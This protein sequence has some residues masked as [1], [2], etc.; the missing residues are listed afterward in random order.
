LGSPNWGLQEDGSRVSFDALR[1]EHPITSGPYRIE[2]AIE[3]RGITYHR[4]PD[5]WGTN[6]PSRRGTLNFDQVVYKLYKDRDTQ[7]SALRAGQ[8][9]FFMEHQM[10]YWCCQYIGHRFNS[11]EL[12]KE[13]VAHQNP[14]AM[15][16]HGFNLRHA[17]FQDPK[18]REALNYALDFEWV[19]QKI[20]DNHFGRVYSYFATT[21]LAASGL[22]SAEELEILEPWR[23]QLDPAV[24]GPMVQLPTTKAPS[25]LRKNLM[26]SLELFAE[27]GW[28]YR[29]GA[30]RNKAGEPFVIEVSGSRG[31]NML[32]DPY[33]LNLSKIGIEVRRRNSDAAT[34][35]ALMTDFNFDF[36]P[37]GLREGRMPG[38]ELWRKFNSADATVPGSE[39]IL[40][41]SSPVIDALINK[42]LDADSEAELT[43]TAR[44]LDRVL[45]HGHYIQ[46]WRY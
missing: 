16:G 9:D 19:N 18:V 23:E 10:R 42:L 17:R 27:A 24:F 40:G 44:A 28:T 1:H 15:V 12:I 26:R 13:K 4:N 30:L 39:N 7:V 34:S 5:Y 33:Y 32:M 41:V 37:I 14:P 38:A 20:F 36:A 11:G 8:Y 25:S 31:A 6:I 3:S 45:M 43:Y 46:P 21:P 2:R 35:R 22:P 29:D